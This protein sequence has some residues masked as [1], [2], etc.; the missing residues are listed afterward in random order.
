ME[1]IALNWYGSTAVLVIA[2]DGVLVAY[3]SRACFP[4]AR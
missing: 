2:S 1:I 3:R 4:E